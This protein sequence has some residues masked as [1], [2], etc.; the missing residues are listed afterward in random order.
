M[1]TVKEKMVTQ[2]FDKWLKERAEAGDVK[3][4]CTTLRLRA[5]MISHQIVIFQVWDDDEG[6]EIFVQ[7]TP[8]NNAREAIAG[9]D[10][11]LART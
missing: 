9:L 7:S 2:P 1:A 3:V 6:W 4:L 8:G 10:E 11:A 5:Y